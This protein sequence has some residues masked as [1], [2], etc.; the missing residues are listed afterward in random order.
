MLN[1]LSRNMLAFKRSCGALESR[2][3]QLKF[4][5][6]ISLPVFTASG[7][8]GGDG[9][10]IKVALIDALADKVVDSGP[11]SSA[12]TEIVVLE[13]DLDSET[14][15]NWTR[16]RTLTICCAQVSRFWALAFLLKCE[17]SLWTM[18]EHV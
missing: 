9:S 8:E 1:W 16:R 2:S 5:N 18:L 13:G 7:V 17:K 12:K 15:L 11:E 6:A 10:A 14:A 4:Q 3:L